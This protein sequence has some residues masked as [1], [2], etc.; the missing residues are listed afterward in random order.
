MDKNK[1]PEHIRIDER[2][3]VGKPLLEQLK[4]LQWEVF[5]GRR[6]NLTLIGVEVDPSTGC[7]LL[8]LC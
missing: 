6:L 1:T 4:D 7:K 5:V 2:N 8:I 3:Y